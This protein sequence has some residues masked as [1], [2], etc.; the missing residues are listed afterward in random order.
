MGHFA[1]KEQLQLAA[2]EW[3]IARFLEEVW[4]PVASHEPG[5]ARLRS[6]MEAWLSYLERDVF[7]GGCF[8]TAVSLEFDDRPGVVRTAIADAWRRWLELLEREA[9]AAQSRGELAGDLSPRQVAFQ[10]HAYIGEANW[11][12]QLLRRPDAAHAS[13]TAI[14]NLLGNA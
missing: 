3:G 10:L 13:R 6:I 8:L 5:L 1:S 11:A 9:A 12:R 4:A 7:P 2:V 14:A